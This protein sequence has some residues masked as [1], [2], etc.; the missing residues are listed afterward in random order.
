MDACRRFERAVASVYRGSRLSR[1]EG[2]CVVDVYDPELGREVME[3]AKLAP[4][5]I[6]ETRIDW[7]SYAKAT[8]AG[9]VG[10]R[11]EGGMWV[12]YGDVPVPVNPYRFGTV[13]LKLPPVCAVT[14]VHFHRIPRGAVV[15]HLHFVCST[16]SPD[17]TIEA[18][19][20]LLEAVKEASRQLLGG[21]AF[22]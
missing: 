19:E 1:E 3:L 5:R 6:G 7:V 22:E 9:A 8:A 15:A 4:S 12:S 14:E 17:K 11:R 13:R 18:T 2:Y 16:P 20:K 10:L 21:R